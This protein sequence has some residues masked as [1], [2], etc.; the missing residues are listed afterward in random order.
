[1][2][3]RCTKPAF[4]FVQQVEHGKQLVKQLYAAGMPAE[5]V[6]GNHSIDYRK[7]LIR[8]LVSGQIEVLVCS[9]IFN[10]G[11]DVPELRS[12]ING[13]GGKSLIATF[14]RLGRGMRVD[15]R[16][17]GSVTDGGDKFEVWDV[18]DAGNKWTERHA[19]L[20]QSAYAS[21]GYETFV[22]PEVRMPVKTKRAVDSV[23]RLAK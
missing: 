21:E 11:I 16:A 9:T 22:E 3:K 6:W 23:G 12:V 14:Q 10:E 13:G 7:S 15:R 4:L 20:R 18:L 17:D 19:R 1:M 2:A 5:F 8:R